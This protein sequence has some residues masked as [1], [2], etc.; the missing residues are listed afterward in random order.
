MINKLSDLKV[1]IQKLVGK[2]QTGNL[3]FREIQ[4][5]NLLSVW[6]KDWYEYT[7]SIY[8]QFKWTV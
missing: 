3:Y 8:G 7:L 2:P 1:N 6:H 4:P 5:F